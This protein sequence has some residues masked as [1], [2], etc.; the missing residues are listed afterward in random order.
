[1]KSCSAKPGYHF[2]QYQPSRPHH[3]IRNNDKTPEGSSFSTNAFGGSYL[4]IYNIN[5]QSADFCPV[6]LTVVFTST[7]SSACGNTSRQLFST[8]RNAF[9]SASH[10]RFPSRSTSLR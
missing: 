2:I 6:L 5:S 3:S 9:G 8:L 7:V 1:M 10:S 4:L